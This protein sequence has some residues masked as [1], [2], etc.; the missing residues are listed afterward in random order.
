M[1][2]LVTS[3]CA[4]LDALSLNCK[5]FKYLSLMIESSFSGLSDFKSKLGYI[6]Y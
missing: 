6:Y 5:L 3:L 2:V 1:E 4:N